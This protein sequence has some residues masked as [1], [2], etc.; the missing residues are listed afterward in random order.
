M[1]PAACG[2]PVYSEVFV[3]V[4]VRLRTFYCKYGLVISNGLGGM[5]DHAFGALRSICPQVNSASHSLIRRT[6][7]GNCKHC[8][9]SKRI[10]VQVAIRS[11]YIL[12]GNAIPVPL[13]KPE[14]YETKRCVKQDGEM[15]GVPT[16][17]GTRDQ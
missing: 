15:I 8:T 12:C 9:V 11:S 5:Y 1:L 6:C 10:C 17:P 2:T 16:R 13:Y 4:S 3:S 14:L 7:P